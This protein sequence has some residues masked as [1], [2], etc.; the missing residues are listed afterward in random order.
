[1]AALKLIEATSA[2]AAVLAGLHHAIDP[3]PWDERAFVTLLTMPG[4]FALIA[5]WRPD[6]STQ[7]ASSAQEPL[8][9]LIARTAGDEMEVLLIAVVAAARNRGIGTRLL[10]AA[11]RYGARAGAERLVL[12]VAEDNMTARTLYARAG[13]VPVG[14]RPGY[15]NRGADKQLEAVDALILA[16]TI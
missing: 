10:R 5:L 14:R 6:K 2:H 7:E 1:M 8:G 12:E 4:T 13:F 15:Y 9:F 16:A 3:D 11:I